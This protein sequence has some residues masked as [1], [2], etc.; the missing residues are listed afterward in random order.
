M[1][2]N[3]T[4]RGELMRNE[5]DRRYGANPSWGKGRTTDPRGTVERVL[6][7]LNRRFV[8]SVPHQERNWNDS[9]ERRA[10]QLR[11]Q[12]RVRRQRGLQR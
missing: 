12:E 2:G 11:E 3:F 4:T 8:S 7:S 9:P 6:G 10:T 1:A 5:L